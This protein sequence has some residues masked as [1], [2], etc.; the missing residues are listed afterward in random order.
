MQDKW[1]KDSTKK[2]RLRAVRNLKFPGGTPTPGDIAQRK[3]ISQ[4][5]ID[6]PELE[7]NVVQDL[8][9]DYILNNVSDQESL[10]LEQH[11]TECPPCMRGIIVIRCTIEQLVKE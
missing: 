5:G 3:M 11:C 2:K 1:P 4:A 10:R 9:V 6:Q 8:M 7:C